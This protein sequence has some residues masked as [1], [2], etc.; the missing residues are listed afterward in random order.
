MPPQIPV[1]LQVPS[2]STLTGTLQTSA[3][4]HLLQKMGQRVCFSAVWFYHTK[5]AAI[6]YHLLSML[7]NN[8]DGLPPSCSQCP[9]D[10]DSSNWICFPQPTMN[11]NQN[12]C[13]RPVLVLQLYMEPKTRQQ[14]LAIRSICIT[15][16][17]KCCDELAPNI[18]QVCALGNGSVP[19]RNNLNVDV[20]SAD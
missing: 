11:Y 1:H 10:L 13:I 7:P 8:P 14:F 17:Y 3:Q 20:I 15:I 5:M 4:S 18:S 16:Q 12:Q 19:I 2:N 9:L 6:L